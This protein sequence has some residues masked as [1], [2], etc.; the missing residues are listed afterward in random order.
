MTWGV[1][2]H[3]SVAEDLDA[4]GTVATRRALIAIDERIHRGQPN[5]SGKPLRGDLAGC[6]RIRIGDHRIVYEIDPRRR[7]VIILA[8]GPR[9]DEEV[10]RSAEARR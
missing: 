10:Y 6:R 3:P 7:R 1:E 8:I 2:Y 9:R 5:Q 4:L